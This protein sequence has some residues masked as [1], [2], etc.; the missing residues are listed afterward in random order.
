MADEVTS[1][2][3][4]LLIRLLSAQR[5]RL[6]Q[7]A[8]VLEHQKTYT[9]L[10]FLTDVQDGVWYELRQPQ[11]VIDPV[12]RSLQ[13]V[14]ATD[15]RPGVDPDADRGEALD[16]LERADDLNPQPD[17]GGGILGA[18]HESVAD[19]LDLLGFVRRQQGTHPVVEL[20]GDVGR[21]VVAPRGGKRGE[22]HEIGEEKRV[23][24]SRHWHTA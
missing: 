6:L 12:R 20:E 13:R 19:G 5:F 8:E 16:G 21:V 1:Q 23:P 22:A 2:Q 10:Q 9:A 17:R 24:C 11:P 14:A 18:E 7:D 4:S 15:R 3:K